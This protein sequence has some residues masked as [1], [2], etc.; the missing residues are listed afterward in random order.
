LKVG[1][2]RGNISRLN[3]E[4]GSAAFVHGDHPSDLYLGGRHR[5]SCFASRSDGFLLAMVSESAVPYL[6]E[7]M[8]FQWAE[9]LLGNLKKVS[10]SSR[11]QDL[12]SRQ[13]SAIYYSARLRI[14][15]V[16]G[17]RNI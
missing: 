15:T 1:F 8:V 9:I 17:D 3:F 4:S 2:W 13:S 12:A 11:H 10:A 14:E 5:L 6:P 7:V 16:F